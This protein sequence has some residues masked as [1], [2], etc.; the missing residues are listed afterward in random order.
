MRVGEGSTQHIEKK[1]QE[2]WVLFSRRK[3]LSS[4][5]I[6]LHTHIYECDYIMSFN[7]TD[8]LSHSESIL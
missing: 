6:I 1:Q 8:K 3:K 7:N 2:N 4:L 5:L